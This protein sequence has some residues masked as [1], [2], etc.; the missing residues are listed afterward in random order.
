MNSM[1]RAYDEYLSSHRDYERRRLAFLRAYFRI[2]HRIRIRGLEHLPEGPAVIAANHSGGFDLD[3]LAISACGHPL[4]AV[5]VLYWEKYHFLNHWWGRTAVGESVPV[6]P[7]NDLPWEIL[8]RYFLPGGERYPGLICVFPE[9]SSRIFRDRRSLGRFYPGAARIALRYGVPVVPAAMIGFH[10]AC[11]ILKSVPRKG[12]PDDPI[13]FLPV[14]FP[15][16]LTIRYG[17]PLD[18]RMYHDAIN[19]RRRQSEIAEL[20][21]KPRVAALMREYDGSFEG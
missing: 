18:M 5:T 11:P 9:G 7:G 8:D 6:A 2:Y 14:T 4:R 13:H 1:I 21:V 20:I 16:R 3:T 12:M 17:E 19:D 10:R 15:F